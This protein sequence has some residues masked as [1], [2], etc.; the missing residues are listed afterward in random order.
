MTQ[1]RQ[2]M[3][4]DIGYPQPRRQY[5]V[6]LPAT[7]YRLRRTLSP[8]AGRAWPGSDSRLSAL[9]DADPQAFAEQ[10]WCRH[11]RAALSVQSHTQT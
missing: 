3:I 10:C 6:G 9:F 8:F 5:P 1:L 4:E 2:R 11:R 7:N